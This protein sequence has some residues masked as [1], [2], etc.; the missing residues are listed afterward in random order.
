M[1]DLTTYTYQT[2]LAVSGMGREAYPYPRDHRRVAE[3]AG[4]VAV[5]GAHLLLGGHHAA[6]A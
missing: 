3:G 6:D 5:P 2:L 4:P 1:T